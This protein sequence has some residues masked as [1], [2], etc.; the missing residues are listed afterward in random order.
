MLAVAQKGYCLPIME[1]EVK[2]DGNVEV[3]PDEFC[4]ICFDLNI[5]D[6]SDKLWEELDSAIVNEKIK[7]LKR[8]DGLYRDQQWCRMDHKGIKFDYIC[9]N[10]EVKEN[11]PVQY[12]IRAG[13]HDTM[14]SY[15]ETEVEVPVDLHKYNGLVKNLLHRYIDDVFFKNI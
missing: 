14:D 12:S 4:G 2:V 3:F 15:M 7:Y 5:I 1:K 10:I 9:L 13:F 6:L 11:R 8:Y